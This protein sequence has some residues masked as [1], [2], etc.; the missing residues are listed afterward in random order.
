MDADDVD[1]AD[2]AGAKE[3][4]LLVS[5]DAADSGGLKIPGFLDVSA[6]ALLE[7]EPFLTKTSF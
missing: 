4:V 7:S 2:D 5:D 3:N 6:A 1:G